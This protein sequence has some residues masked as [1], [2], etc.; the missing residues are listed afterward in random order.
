[1]TTDPAIPI[2]HVDAFADAPFEGNP[3]A[4]CVLGADRALVHEVAD[5]PLA[6]L[7]HD[8]HRAPPA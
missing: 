8:L 3:A 4:V 6:E 5:C 7:L 1:M 2:I